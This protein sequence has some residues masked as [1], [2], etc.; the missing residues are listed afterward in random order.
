MMKPAVLLLALATMLAPAET[1]AAAAAD[2][3]IVAPQPWQVVQRV[4]YDPRRAWVNQPGGP[5]L[6]HADVAVRAIPPAAGWST[7]ETRV[8]ALRP[9]DEKKP[10]VD[11]SPAKLNRDKG[12]VAF[13]VRTPAGGWY[14][15]E[16]RFQEGATTV[17]TAAV[18]PFG[19]GELFIIAGQSY[20]TN[21]N[22]ERLTPADPDRRAVA[23]DAAAK[24]WRPAVDP[25]P[26][27]DGSDGGSIWPPFA[28]LLVPALGV[29]IGFVNVAWGGASSEQWLSG[30]QLHARLVDAG[31]AVGPVH[32]V[33]WQQG[34]SDVIAKTSTEKYV[35]NIA[36][37]R[38]AAENA[39]G[40]SPPWL[41]AKSTLHPTVYVD[42]EGEAR[43]RNGI[44]VLCA[45]PGFRP[46]PDTDMLGGLHR[47]G[48]TTRRH[49]SGPGQRAAAA[50]WFAEVWKLL[51]QPP[52]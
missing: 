41:L 11:W 10:V 23:Y 19:V 8:V 29:P 16:V 1:A 9:D 14:R 39:W 46:G 49:F 7:V 18:E 47:G 38:A 13:I 2:P 32:A 28:D 48:P 42:P 52:E 37:V 36:A 25:Q 24:S 34:E 4:G 15:L 30:G 40:R 21:C 3:R 5:A 12:R 17:G 43:I 20:A 6:G 50:L 44:D 45:K 51:N 27:P 33:L 26:A 22:D 35:E 31:K